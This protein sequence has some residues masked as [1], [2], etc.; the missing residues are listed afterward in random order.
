MPSQAVYQW[1]VQFAIF[2]AQ[3]P[4]DTG[5]DPGESVF[6]SAR[7]GVRLHMRM[8]GPRNSGVTPI[9]CLP[10][11][12]RNSRDFLGLANHFANHDKTPRRVVAFDFRGRGLSDYAPDWRQYNLITEAE[13]VI[14]GLTALNIEHA[15]FIGTSRGGL[16]TMA[17]TAMRPGA[18]AA[19]VLN[20][21]GPVIDGEGIARI[22]LYLKEQPR[23]RDW[24]EA[25]AIQK[26]IM[27]KLFPILTEDNWR[28]EAAARYRTIDGQIRP[29]HDPSLI[30]TMTS[31]DLGDR[32][33]TMWPQFIG[34]RGVP[35]LAI[36]G[37]NSALLSQRTIDAM[38]E[39]HPKLSRLVAPGQGHAPMLHTPDMLEG[40]EAFVQSQR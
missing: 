2:M 4:I 15:I 38:A 24:D 23:P 16:V 40:I 28:F 29:D 37:E 12:S 9:V 21:I 32:L 27:D 11:L 14:D 13:D 31:I 10:G 20:D 39:R 25:I 1:L 18:I 34:L 8:F 33:P 17:L 30:K 26:R 5:F 3:S 19:A 35:V 36:R 6:V 7:D 22:R